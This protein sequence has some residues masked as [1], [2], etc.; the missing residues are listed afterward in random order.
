MIRTARR[1][2]VLLMLPCLL[3]AC[4][5][6]PKGVRPVA[7]FELERYLGKWYE[8]AR[9]DHSFERGLTRVTAEYSLRE[10]GGVR[11]INRGF[12]AAKQEWNEAE[13]KAYFVEGEDQGYLKVSFFGPFYGSYVVFELDREAYQYAFIA[14]PDTSYLWL[15]ARTP[16]V[17]DEVL[18]RFTERAAELGFATDSLILVAQD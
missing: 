12:S 5:G 11:V 13:G 6:M 2:I 10:D 18:R 9:L 14:G 3:A 7:G 15:L 17:S 4:L 1:L 16:V 8:I